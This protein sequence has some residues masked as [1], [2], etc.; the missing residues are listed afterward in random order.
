MPFKT[1]KFWYQKT[2]TA[3]LIQSVLTPLSWFYQMGHNINTQKQFTKKVNIPIICVGNIT[4]GGSGKTPT[5]IA[6]NN[7]IAEHKMFKE[8]CFLTR[9]Y[10]AKN[11]TTRFIS[12]HEPTQDTGD[13]PKILLN[14]SK[15]II[16]KNRYEGAK[17]AQAMN[18]D[19]IIMDDGFQNNTLHKD[20]SFLVIDGNTGFGNAKTLPAG[21][22][23]EPITHGIKRADAIIIIGEDKLDNVN[24]IPPG[25]PV[26]NASIKPNIGQI[27]LSQEYFAFCGLA[28]PSKFFNTL[29]TSNIKVIEHKTFADHHPYDETELY[30]LINR[31]KKRN[32]KLITTEKD[33]VKIPEKFHD[34][35]QTLPIN[36]VFNDEKQ[37]SE[38]LKN[39]LSGYIEHT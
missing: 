35:I 34:K 3:A 11:Q 12:D 21:P 20:I 18:H 7:I 37:L 23:R 13:E 33:I 4:A 17:L 2:N 36:L 30:D 19:I 5:A 1:P 6:I 16:S 10:G 39:K 24:N 22:L 27:D 29:K 38:F 8:A 28:H 14:H 26:F 15:T 31:A 32:A 9:G 25:K